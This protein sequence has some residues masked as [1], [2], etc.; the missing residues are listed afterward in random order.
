MF[1][2]V[3]AAHG[4]GGAGHAAGTGHAVGTGRAVGN[5]HAVS[6]TADPNHHNSTGA[7][8]ASSMPLNLQRPQ[9]GPCGVQHTASHAPAAGLPAKTIGP[10]VKA[11]I[12]PGTATGVAVHC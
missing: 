5:G 10:G 8:R 6:K 4:S 2:T 11:G 1:S 7:Q 9:I 3:V 12:G